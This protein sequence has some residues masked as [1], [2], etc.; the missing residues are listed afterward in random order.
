MPRWGRR[1]T[2]PAGRGAHLKRCAENPDRPRS[3]RPRIDAGLDTPVG[4]LPIRACE[5]VWT[6]SCNIPNDAVG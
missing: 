3:P 5:D 6:S 4:P 1:K 2:P